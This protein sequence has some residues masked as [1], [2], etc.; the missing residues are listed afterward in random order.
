MQTFEAQE[1]ED[2]EAGSKVVAKSKSGKSSKNSRSRKPAATKPQKNTI[3]KA[4]AKQAAKPKPSEKNIAKD[5]KPKEDWGFS[6]DSEGQQMLSLSERLALKKYEDTSDATS[7]VSS[8]QVGKTSA[9]TSEAASSV[10]FG[11]KAKKSKLKET[12]DSESS[13]SSKTSKN[14]VK[15]LKSP[16]KRVR[17]LTLYLFDIQ[18]T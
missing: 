10:A 11:S 6:D 14:K 2:A 9:S 7:S 16:A 12:S 4:F 18:K 15:K 8:K 13:V 17:C 5:E 3:E 1:R